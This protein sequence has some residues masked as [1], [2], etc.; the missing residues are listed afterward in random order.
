M[1]FFRREQEFVVTKTTGPASYFL[2]V[3]LGAPTD[4]ISVESIDQRPDSDSF[5]R[6]ILEGIADFNRNAP[7]AVHV[8]RVRFAAS[9][10]GNPAGYRWLVQKLLGRA[11]ASEPF[12]GVE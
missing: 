10:G 7:A 4:E 11:S 5:R 1:H 12:D 3:E 9:D 8:R 6:E 2:A